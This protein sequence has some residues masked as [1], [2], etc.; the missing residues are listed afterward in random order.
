MV[1]EAR[2]SVDILERL[3]KVSRGFE[4]RWTDLGIMHERSCASGVF[5]GCG[6]SPGLIAFHCGIVGECRRVERLWAGDMKGTGF[7]ATVA[8]CSLCWD[9]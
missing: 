4:M 1:W 3:V 9:C 8:A 2:F 7:K 6:M 5:K